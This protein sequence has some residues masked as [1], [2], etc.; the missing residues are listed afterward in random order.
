MIELTYR[1]PDEPGAVVGER[2]GVLRFEPR[3]Y[4]QF[5]GR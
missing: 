1:L 3:H 2:G 5:S 4:A